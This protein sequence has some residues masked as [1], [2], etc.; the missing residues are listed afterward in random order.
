[1]KH[2]IFS[3]Y[4]S[5]AKAYYPPFFLPNNGMAIRQFTDMVNST[6]TSISKNPKDY[7][8]FNL[9]IFDDGDGSIVPALNQGNLGLGS[10][11]FDG[12]VNEL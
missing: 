11:F 2:N 6:T 1:M 3:I 9:G 12:T 4:D 7:T 5:V 8:L 10:S